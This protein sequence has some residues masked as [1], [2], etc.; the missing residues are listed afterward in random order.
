MYGHVR[1]TPDEVYDHIV[2]LGQADHWLKYFCN[3]VWRTP[4]HTGVDSVFD[5]TFDFMT[6]RVRTMVDDRGGRWAAAVDRCSLPIAN[7]MLEDVRLSD[8][9]A[10][11]TDV[12]WKIHYD[13]PLLITP[14]AGLGN[15]FFEYMLNKSL[16]QLDALVG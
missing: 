9:G 11:G 10:G 13:P 16:E 12:D 3:V 8:D 14:A 4:S 6:I 5:E 15:A 2:G 1:A 7:K